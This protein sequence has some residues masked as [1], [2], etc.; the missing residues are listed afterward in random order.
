[1]RVT[2]VTL[3]DVFPVGHSDSGCTDENISM[4][5]IDMPLI[6]LRQEAKLPAINNK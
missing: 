4:A 6:L 3:C 2:A 1:M 5:N